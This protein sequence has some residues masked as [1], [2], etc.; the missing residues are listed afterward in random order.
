MPSLGGVRLPV[1]VG[2]IVVART[3]PIDLGHGADAPR[4]GRSTDDSEPSPRHCSALDPGP[5]RWPRHG[6]VVL[7]SRCW[8]R[9]LGLALRSTVA[10]PPEARPMPTATA[11]STSPSSAVVAAAVLGPRVSSCL[12]YTSPSPRD[13]LLSR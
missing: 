1:G 13:G 4:E 3:L 7:A 10:S 5:R 2:V 12:L 9:G 11:R 6:L 8:C